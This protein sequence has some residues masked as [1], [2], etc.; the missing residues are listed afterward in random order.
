MPR[1]LRTVSLLALILCAALPAFA[2]KRTE[3]VPAEIQME[4]RV[5]NTLTF[6]DKLKKSPLGKLW[7]DQ[8]FQDFIGNPGEDVWNEVL[9][10]GEK[11]A[12][13]EIMIEQLKM[14]RGEVIFAMGMNDDD[15]PYA[16][17]AMSEEDFRRSLVLDEK[18]KE[19]GE[20]PFDIVKSS[21]QDIEV[22]EHISNPATE[23]ESHSWQ[24]HLNNTLVMGPSRE[25]VEKSIIRLKGES[26]EEPEGNPELNFRVPLAALIQIAVKEAEK[27]E[28][29]NP[30]SVN[31]QALFEALGLMGIEDFSMRVELM[32]NELTV[33]NN[34]VATSLNKGIFT[35]LNMDPAEIPT[36]GFVPENISLLEVGRLD[37][38]HF[39]QEIPAVL[40]AAMPEAKPQ[41]DMVM[42]M[43]R[44]QTGID[45]EL[46]LLSH[47]GT[48]YL[49]FT[50][51]EN[52]AMVNVM[53]LELRDGP[54]FKRG[55]ESIL[56]SPVLKPQVTA[57]LDTVDFLDHT[58]YVTKN[59][60]PADTVSFAV[61]GNYLLYGHPDGVRQ[62]IR[63][64]SSEAAANP[65]FEQS[66]LVQ[67]LRRNT[68]S[69]AFGYSA[70]DW[71]KNMAFVIR[72]LAKPQISRVFLG[73]WATSG[74]PIPPPD[75]NKLPSADHL[76]SF[77]GTSYQY[78][79][80]TDRGLHQKI[81]LK[82]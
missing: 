76:A 50:S 37:L 52:E 66:E 49:G 73:Q 25:W 5:S 43:I 28:S 70:I 13:D 64:V 72:E 23:E 44:Q 4:I 27:E 54:A 35:I 8:E 31:T 62:V 30:T 48:R 77:F 10:E 58:L 81:I 18:M 51:F 39:W 78:V 41:Y 19:V 56:N 6:W 36:V 1:T 15:D 79:E 21:F 26:V 24:A 53:A 68:P 29:A 38:L 3:L 57:A 75:M 67:G 12:E 33:D 59:T 11:T 47:L 32:D 82:Y 20:E 17:I 9:F 55:L 14:A 40:M 63:S 74:S 42:G 80:K 61:A 22:I 2:L 71:K 34:L 16:V 65:R 60:E 7:V 45:I 69:N 46:D